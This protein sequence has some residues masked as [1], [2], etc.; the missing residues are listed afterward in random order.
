MIGG[1][2]GEW[3]QQ[4]P[5]LGSFIAQKTDPQQDDDKDESPP[6]TLQVCIIFLPNNISC[7]I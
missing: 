1:G 5:S 7:L 4:A 2:G 3:R 6:S